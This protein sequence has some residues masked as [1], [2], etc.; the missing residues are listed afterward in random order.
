MRT[1]EVVIVNPTDSG[2]G[3]AV[4]QRAFGDAELLRPLLH[5]LQAS[6]YIVDR[7]RRI[8]YWNRA[9]EQ[10]TGYLRHEVADRYCHQDLL[11]HCDVEGEVLCGRRC[12]L[13]GVLED[14]KPRECAAFLRHKAGHRVPVR[15]RT[16]P[17]HGAE[18]EV[19]GALEAFE[20]AMAPGRTGLAPKEE[21]GRLDQGTG[22]LDRAYGELQ[23][24]H[25]L[26][27]ASWFN[28]ALGWIRVELDGAD[29]L[30]HR[31]GHGLIDA[32]MRM[33]ARTLDANVGSRDEVIRWDRTAFS[34]LVH[35]ASPAQLADLA[36][37]LAV[38]V[39]ASNV[40]W[41][42]EPLCVTSSVAASK[43]G[44]SDSFRSIEDRV[45]RLVERCRA[46]GGNRAEYDFD[47][48]EQPG[49][50]CTP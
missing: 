44:S 38:M 11:M 37:K 43:A 50:F 12:P 23:L 18:G 36:G 45:V 32:A 22:A 46:R 3:G 27:A 19:I 21:D 25:A 15:V 8:V 20:T 24:T 34:V 6:V 35:D 42:G 7:K 30:A 14:G 28:L 13:A 26:H 16:R 31:Y 39:R 49:P 17:V 5:D 10:S 40:E 29:S 47:P 33:M 41:W 1:G 2:P 48:G 9:A 4:L